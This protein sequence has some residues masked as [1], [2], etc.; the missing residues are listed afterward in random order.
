MQKSMNT[1]AFGGAFIDSEPQCPLGGDRGDHVHRSSGTGGRDHGGAAHRRPGG[2]GVMIG[3]QPGLIRKV[4]H[5]ALG[6]GM[7]AQR[8]KRLA[9]PGF[10]RFEVCW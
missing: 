8:K 2:A 1:S 9:F 3:A 7:G 10:D 5:G 4:D 6:R